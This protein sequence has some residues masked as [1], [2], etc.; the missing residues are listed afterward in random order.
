VQASLRSR[1]RAKLSDI[2][3]VPI[4]VRPKWTPEEIQRE[5]DNN[6][7]G[8]LGYVMRWIDQGVGC[9]KVPEDPATLRISS[10]HMANWLHHGVVSE[11]QIVETMKRMACVVDEQ[12]EGDPRYMRIA[13]N[14]HC[15]AA[16]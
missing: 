4:A 11:A 9:S 15:S 12:D 7:Q 14:Y 1:P 3:S 2:L 6:A 8:M 10:Q 13:G 16:F 5:L